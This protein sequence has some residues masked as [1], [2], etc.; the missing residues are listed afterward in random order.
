MTWKFL[1]RISSG[2]PVAVVACFSMED[3]WL[4][5]TCTGIENGYVKWFKSSK[6][7]TVA[8]KRSARTQQLPLLFQKIL[9]HVFLHFCSNLQHQAPEVPGTWPTDKEALLETF[10]CS[11]ISLVMLSKAFCLIV[12]LFVFKCMLTVIRKRALLSICI[13][14]RWTHI[15]YIKLTEVSWLKCWSC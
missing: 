7:K 1:Q 14:K 13:V 6:R 10:S 12:C 9:T 11:D 8:C 2:Q 3:I 5:R 4:W 15:S